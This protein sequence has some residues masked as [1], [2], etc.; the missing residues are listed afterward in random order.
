MI[1]TSEII[2]YGIITVGILV[3]FSSFWYHSVK[4]MTVNL[5]VVWEILG[6][7]LIAIGSVPVLSSWTHLISMGTGLGL[8]IVGAVCLWGGFQ[9]SLLVSRLAMKN[10]ELAIQVSLLIQENEKLIQQFEELTDRIRKYE[11]K[12]AIR[13]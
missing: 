11:E 10:Q 13:D 12:A 1:G 9:F 2:K 3:M 6:A 4:K 5:A 7:I 8:F